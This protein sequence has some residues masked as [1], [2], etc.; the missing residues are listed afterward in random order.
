MKSGKIQQGA[1]TGTHNNLQ[2]QSMPSSSSSSRSSGISRGG[3]SSEK[4]ESGSLSSA[5]ESTPLLAQDELGQQ[6]AARLG[7]N[8]LPEQQ[9]TFDNIVAESTAKDPKWFENIQ[10]SSSTPSVTSPPSAAAA[11]NNRW[12]T[13]K[14]GVSDRVSAAHK[15]ASDQWKGMKQGASDRWNQW[16]TGG[17]SSISSSSSEISKDLVGV[18]ETGGEE[19]AMLIAAGG[20]GELMAG[21]TAVEA[22]GAGSVLAPIAAAVAPVV[23]I[24]VVGQTLSDDARGNM[25]DF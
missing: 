8:G 17:G 4:L 16:K 18:G 10:S 2:Q 19:E 5:E 25:F 22:A 15:G 6:S 13:L 24:G 23:A 3:G 1:S 21:S 14:Q 9:A 12:N 11:A 20:Q 7:H